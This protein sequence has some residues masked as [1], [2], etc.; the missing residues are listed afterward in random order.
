MNSSSRLTRSER[1]LANSETGW[2]ASRASWTRRYA[3]FTLQRTKINFNHLFTSQ[4]PLLEKLEEEQVSLLR[5][6]HDLVNSRRLADDEDDLTTFF[7]PLPVVDTPQTEPEETDDLGRMI[8]KPSPTELR[9]ERRAARAMRHEQRLRKRSTAAGD[10]EEGY[11]TD[12]SLPPPDEEDYRSAVSGLSSQLKDVLADVRA[13][14][15]RN[16]TGAKWNAWREKYGDT[17]RNAWGG[18]GVV[19]A[20]E[21]W[22]RLEIT[23]W[24]CIEVRAEFYR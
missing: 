11:S 18:L 6:R 19:S 4:Y 17:Y 3:G 21:F 15:F 1:G 14:E 5:E 22:V 2:R 23:G 24:D 20:W 7:G 8:P 9:K 13:E 16:P 12:S 10:Q